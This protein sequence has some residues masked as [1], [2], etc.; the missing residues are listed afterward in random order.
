MGQHAR[1]DSDLAKWDVDPMP[2]LQKHGLTAVVVVAALSVIATTSLFAFLSY[3]FIFWRAKYSRYIGYNQYVVLIYNLILA[4][5]MQSIAFILSVEHV[6]REKITASS[7]ACFAQG[8]LL[9]IGDPASGIFVFA[10][11]LHTFLL[12]T[13]RH[14]LGY[15]AFVTC[16]I[17]VWCLIA[18]L[19]LVPT[20]LY[21]R[22]AYVPSGAWVSLIQ[23]IRTN[24]SE[25]MH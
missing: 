8:L 14:K 22:Y 23:F 11:S 6:R 10:I 15:R 20:G 9:Q 12:V 24:K 19:V 25:N 13:M 18:L 4:D 5:L 7:A 16:V 2:T 21:G 1:T 3:R 17:G